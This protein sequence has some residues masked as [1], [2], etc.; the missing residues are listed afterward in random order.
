MKT[1]SSLLKYALLAAAM[2]IMNPIEYRQYV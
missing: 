1:K 2:F